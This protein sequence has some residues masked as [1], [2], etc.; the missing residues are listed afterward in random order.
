MCVKKLDT[1][2]S[3]AVVVNWL[4]ST[5]LH[6]CV[7]GISTSRL[8]RVPFSVASSFRAMSKKACLVRAPMVR[9]EGES[10][11]LW[12]RRAVKWAP[13]RIFHVRRWLLVRLRVTA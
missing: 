5:V 8:L 1:C 7:L 12:R 3:F 10:A 9:A 13:S 4:I 11:H 2:V 6:R